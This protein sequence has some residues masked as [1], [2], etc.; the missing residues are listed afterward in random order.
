MVLGSAPLRLSKVTWAK[1]MPFHLQP[2]K[3]AQ[4]RQSRKLSNLVKQ[5]NIVRQVARFFTSLLAS[6]DSFLFNCKL[7]DVPGLEERY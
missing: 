1:A 6:R 3:S 5:E 4:P 2:T 7:R